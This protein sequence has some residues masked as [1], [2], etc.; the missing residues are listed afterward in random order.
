M[1]VVR[2]ALLLGCLVGIAFASETPKGQHIP[3]RKLVVL[4]VLERDVE[5]RPFVSPMHVAFDPST[6]EIYISDPGRSELAIFSPDFFPRFSLGRGRG[7]EGPYGIAVDKEGYIYVCQAATLKK[8]PRLSILNG[9]GILEKEFFFRDYPFEGAPDFR[10]R[11]VAV[12]K[13]FIY[14]AGEIFAGVVV[15]D[16]EGR[17]VRI[18]T[19]KDRVA[20]GFPEEK[21]LINDVYVDRKGRLYLVSAQMGR[22]YVYNALG[23]FL[24]KGG[25][26]GGGP[27][28]LSRPSGIAADPNLGL[29]LIIDY[30]RHTG[31]AYS[32]RDGRFLFEF[33]GRGWAPGWFNYPT[34]I[35][36]DPQGRVYVADLFNRRVQV[37]VFGEEEGAYSPVP[38]F[39]TPLRPIETPKKGKKGKPPKKSPGKEAQP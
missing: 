38:S 37:F 34:D 20:P 14:V 11:S 22:F 16:R 3:S 31:L 26:K 8:P 17:F 25:K 24:F 35:A 32:Y 10:P 6:Y 28:K 33:G 23:H 2:G 13:R 1:R 9:A 15:L 21:A 12:G 36:I 5:A 19:I 30:M 27:G 18:I 7:I 4:G 39:I 29:I